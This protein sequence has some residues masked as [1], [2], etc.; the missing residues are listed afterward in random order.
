MRELQLLIKPVSS[1]CDLDCRYCFYKD[2]A[3]NRAVGDHGKMRKET[4]RAVVDK[5]LAASQTCVFG[6]QGGEPTLAGLSFFEDF[7]DYVEEKK[8]PGQEV[9]YSIQTNGCGLDE[10][11]FAF[12][13]EKKF[14]V[15]LSLDGV[16]KTHDENR[17]DR[18]GEGTFSR[19]FDCAVQLQERGIPSNVLCV[20]NAQT[21]PRAGAIYRFF[22]RKGFVWQQYIP[23][24]DPLE[25][26]RG[27][28]I[29][30]LTPKMYGEALA[31]LFDLWF[32]DKAAGR[33]VYIRQFDNYVSVL[34]GGQPE[35][36]SMYGRCSMQN[37]IESD[38]TVYPCDF[39]ALDEW[40]MGNI[41]DDDTDFE[42]LY[43]WSC[44]EEL[45]KK[46]G[47]APFFREPDRRDDRCP[48]CRWY[49]LCRGGCRRDCFAA[50]GGEV[51]NYYCETYQKFFADSIGRLEYLAGGG[52]KGQAN[53][54]PP[55]LV[56]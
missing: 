31:E 18:K 42:I 5:A 49:P 7:T 30:S 47:P 51:K 56:P 8:R 23:C 11:W 33:P 16:R 48:G 25:E 29:F 40:Q 45:G 44:G 43:R 3:A 15:G 9:S 24:L 1:A 27:G 13:K 20:L 36:C 41:C 28:K 38:G 2:E 14:L 4:M 55:S 17:R 12:L 32:Q 21:A 35:A 39:Y 34:L 46:K 22:M 54:L 10:R 6:F 19:V 37:V 52:R 53:C 50:P 26:Q